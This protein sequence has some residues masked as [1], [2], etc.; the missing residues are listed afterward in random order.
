MKRFPLFISLDQA[1]TLVVGGGL[2]ALRKV[3]LLL[4][5][6]KKIQLV[7]EKFHPELE[8]LIKENNLKF[9]KKNFLSII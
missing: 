4:K 3:Q 5:A 7:A 9:F 6:T 2:V 8:K 1:N